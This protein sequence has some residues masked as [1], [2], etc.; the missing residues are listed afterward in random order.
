MADVIHCE[1]SS[2]EFEQPAARAR[3]GR[4]QR[5]RRRT[6]AAADARASLPTE[7]KTAS[8]LQSKFAWGEYSPQEVQR[9]AALIKADIEVA[10]ASGSQFPDLVSLAS[11]GSCGRFTNKCHSEIVNLLQSDDALKP[12]IVAAPIANLTGDPIVEAEVPIF[13]PH[14]TMS[15]I[16]KHHP[17]VWKERVLPDEDCLLYTS[18]SPRDLSTSRMPSSA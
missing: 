11:M 5:K 10:L 3:G 16:Y 2:S 1:E 7:S 18:P 13:E 4:Q 17:H 15:V 8:Y 6:E 14:R 9:L 12:G